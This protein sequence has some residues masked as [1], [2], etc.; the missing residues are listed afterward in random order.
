M[1]QPKVLGYIPLFYGAE[2]L[3]AC[4]KSMEPFVDK[5]IIVYVDR[6]SQG[7][8]TSVP[9][10]ENEEQLKQIAVEAITD[11]DKLEWHSCGTFDNEGAHRNYIFQFANGYDL[12]F[13]LD[14][15]E[16]AEPA[17]VPGALMEA[18]NSNDRFHGIDGFINFW[19][20][21]DYVCL[22]GFRPYRITNL[23]ATGGNNINLKMRIYHFGT[24]Q[25]IET[26]KFKW[27][28][29]GHKNELKPNW[30]SNVYEK[31]TPEN[32]FGDLHPVSVG[33]WNAAA[34]DKYTLPEFLKQHPNFNKR[35]V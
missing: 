19:R 32:I 35:L 30:I 24:C 26:I 27:N 1:K 10:P 12:V 21:F 8:G 18:F 3:G 6:P 9:C 23:R 34:F 2:Y 28:V 25:N 31:W 29:S 22:D 20:S 17:D 13:T 33:L 4:I 5:L 16:V 15:D 11:I 14:A 7:H